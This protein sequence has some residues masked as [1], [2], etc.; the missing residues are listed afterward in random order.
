MIGTLIPAYVFLKLVRQMYFAPTVEKLL[1]APKPMKIALLLSAG[2]AVSLPLLLEPLAR[3][4]AK[5]AGL[6]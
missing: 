2:A 1:P 3:F 4:A 6:F 5:A